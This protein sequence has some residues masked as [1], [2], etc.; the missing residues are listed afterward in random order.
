MTQN[1]STILAK[2]ATP[3]GLAK[4]TAER[5]RRSFWVFVQEMWETVIQEDP[6]WNWHMEYLCDEL[7]E[8]AERVFK[9]QP[10]EYDLVINVPPGSSK[11][12][13]ASVMFPAW[14]WTRDQAIRSICASY[15]SSLSLDI[16]TN[17]RDVVASDKYRALF[18]EI[19]LRE[20]VRG[21]GHF[22]NTNT[23]SRYATSV[24]GTVT[25]MHGHFLI[26]DDPLNPKEASSDADRK[27]ANDW[28]TQTLPSRKIDKAI[29]PTILIMQR[30][31]QHDCTAQMVEREGSTVRHICLPAEDSELVN[32]PE[33]RTRY[34]DGLL[35]PARMPASVLQD[36]KTTLGSY[37]Y[38]G[39]YEQRPTPP[40][41]GMFKV[42]KFIEIQSIP[43][44][45]MRRGIRY[46][47]KA[48]TEGGGC[49]T[50]GVLILEM[51]NTV[52]THWIVADVV[53]GQWSALGRE[54]KIL[55]TA[56]KD[57][58][59]I[60]IWIEQE[61]G[62]GGKADAEATIRNLAGFSCRKEPPA[63][64]K[65]QRANPFATQIEAGQVGILSNAAWYFDY[66]EELRHFPL[67]TYK[68]QVDASS[69]AFNRLVS[70]GGVGTF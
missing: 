23:G 13:I 12:T 63:T 36:E 42:D 19:S 33:L 30:L 64:G 54:D 51:D 38:S 43:W 40:E 20:D 46:W 15:S 39:Q 37:G 18:P 52:S 60:D 41:G 32:P 21:K 26:V 31:H 67:S 57:G 49:Y 8:V 4:I 9:R 25:G 16:A 28:M 69:G 62:S 58:R 61:P 10:K 44:D 55:Q 3:E 48:G 70:G 59:P 34:V 47:D 11:T 5:C 65:E 22:K 27:T 66:I 50:A 7:Q 2:V 14:C 17:S 24:G 35:D 53:R 56:K 45:K 1:L 6:V 29:T 68:D